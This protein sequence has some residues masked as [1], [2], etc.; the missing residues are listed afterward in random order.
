MVA[1]HPLGARVRSDTLKW[2]QFSGSV[3]CSP[4]HFFAPVSFSGSHVSCLE[5]LDNSPVRFLVTHLYNI[6][7]TRL[8][9]LHRR[10]HTEFASNAHWNSLRISR[11]CQCESSRKSRPHSQTRMR[12]GQQNCARTV[13]CFYIL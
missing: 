11:F 7:Y 6:R 1:G 9:L 13:T 2:G 4:V 12:I 5:A 8:D 3:C 10:V